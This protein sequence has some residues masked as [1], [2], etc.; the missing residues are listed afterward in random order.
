MMRDKDTNG[1][2][3]TRPSSSPRAVMTSGGKQLLC[4]S[5]LWGAG[6]GRFSSAYAFALWLRGQHEPSSAME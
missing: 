1:S 2:I 3:C 4:G 6:N 5:A